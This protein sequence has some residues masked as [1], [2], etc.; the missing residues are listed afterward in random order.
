MV[1][2][3]S[4]IFIIGCCALPAFST[5]T[6]P[7]KNTSTTA[8]PP[9]THIA[10]TITPTPSTNAAYNSYNYTKADNTTCL[11]VNMTVY[12]VAVSLYLI[13]LKAVY[14]FFLLLRHPV[15]APQLKITAVQ[16][17]L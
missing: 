8:A 11:M 16:V 2:T 3:F 12:F 7:S 9:T 15:A 6:A 10:T 17:S 1:V 4:G 13:V 14:S 5:T